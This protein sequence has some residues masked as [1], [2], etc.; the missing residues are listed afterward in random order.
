MTGKGVVPV[1]VTV[2][3]LYLGWRAG[4]EAASLPGHAAQMTG[5]KTN[6]SKVIY[7]LFLFLL[8]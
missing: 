8:S 5:G 3:G 1:P 7:L 6:Q 2:A 4:E